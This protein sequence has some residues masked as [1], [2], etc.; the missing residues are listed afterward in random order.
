M[1]LLLF[2]FASA[3]GIQGYLNK[4]RPRIKKKHNIATGH[5]CAAYVSLLNPPSQTL[6][7]MGGGPEVPPCSI[8][9][10]SN[11]GSISRDIAFDVSNS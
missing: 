4:D 11:R 8:L 10:S 3:S 1:R 2:Y 7:L 9:L 6:S 5:R